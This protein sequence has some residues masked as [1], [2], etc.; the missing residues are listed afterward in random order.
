M[1]NKTGRT[2]CSLLTLARPMIVLL[3]FAASLPAQDKPIMAL[4]KAPQTSPTEHTEK[5]PPKHTETLTPQQII[6]LRQIA[7]LRALMG[8]G[9]AERLQGAI[10]GSDPEQ[11]FQQ[12]LENLAI[13]NKTAPPLFRPVSHGRNYRPPTR[14]PQDALRSSAKK[15]EDLAA[16][17]ELVQIYDKADELRELAV[18]Y[19][20][21]A[22]SLK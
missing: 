11:Q 4:G 19:W 6:D 10:P 17:L 22:R 9:V 3:V 13:Q 7:A 2:G 18:K 15:L 5:A 12:S 8:G 1:L 21:Q 16:E 20:L 14:S